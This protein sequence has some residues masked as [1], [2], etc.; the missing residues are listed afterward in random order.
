MK[1]CSRCVM[2]S[3]GDDF[4]K[5][6]ASGKCS[7]CTDALKKMKQ[8][9]FPNKEGKTR[10][11][12][13]I[14]D[15]KRKRKGKYDC[16][17]G[18]S[19]GLDSSYL[20]YLCYRWGLNA[21]VVHIDDGYDTDISK[22][23]INRL[24][25]KTGFDYEVVT[26]DFFQYN[27]LIKAYMMAGVPN[28]AVP[29]DSILFAFLFD[30]A[31]KNHIRYFLSGANFSLE[32][33]LQQ[34]KSWN[35]RDVVNIKSIHKAF[36]TAPIDKLK[37]NSLLRSEI[38]NRIYKLKTMCPLDFVDYRRDRAFKELEEFCGF[39]YYG[40]KHL[41]NKLTA[42]IQLYWLPLKFGVDK[43]TSHL[44]SMIVTN[45]ITREEALKE[46][47]E[48]L[49][50]EGIMNEYISLIKQ[51]LGLSDDDFDRIMKAPTH[52]HSEFRSQS[53]TFIWKCGRLMYH[54]IKG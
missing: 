29:Q 36:G 38:C 1:R 48:P 37:F 45:Q 30:M 28:I 23:N 15:I 9:Y 21:L 53:D 11:K 12:R 6:D 32:C 51:E 22:S 46:L 20:T 17:L 16:I 3:D 40:R 41:E 24:I 31:K 5:F 13:M 42:F 14:S 52:Q 34:G 19:G 2:T 25:E 4:I 27:M 8:T 35:S 50:D 18:L 44:S 54:R 33:I 7:Y 47:E 26:P 43:R 10:I 39:Q 49:Y